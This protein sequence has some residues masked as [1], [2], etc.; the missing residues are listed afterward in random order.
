MDRKVNHQL[1][2]FFK[3][4]KLLRFRKK[5]IIIR[6]GDPFTRVFYLKSGFVRLYILS[7]T[8]REL[9]LFIYPPGSYF[10]TLMGVAKGDS[11][12]YFETKSEVVAYAAPAD[13]FCKFLH[14]NPDILFD[15][16]QRT[17]IMLRRFL[18]QVEVFSTE[19]PYIRTVS[20]II[21][22]HEIYSQ[23]LNK[24]NPIIP[25][26]HQELATW[27]HT[28]RETVSRQIEKLEHNQV[29]KCDKGKIRINDLNR[30]KQIAL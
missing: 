15:L 16:T 27:T 20:T 5:E 12:Y 8:G 2:D 17:N 14:L 6:D 3:S 4:Y 28:T 18:H 21:F 1:A 25:I 30:L 22:L 24:I 13:E 23:A 10:P 19:T 9:S 26:S 29:I 11:T 7:R